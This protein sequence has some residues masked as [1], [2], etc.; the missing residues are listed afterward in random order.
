MMVC[1]VY[2]TLL[3]QVGLMLLPHDGN[4]HNSVAFIA[5]PQHVSCCQ[6]QCQQ[7][8]LWLN[9]WHALAN[10]ALTLNLSHLLLLQVTEIVCSFDGRYVFTSGGED[11]VVNMWTVNTE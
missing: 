7:Q 2:W 5:H 11:C 1:S 10:L 9:G 4:P 3:L 6:S 8:A